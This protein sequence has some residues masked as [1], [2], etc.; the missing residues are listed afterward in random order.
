MQEKFSVTGMTCSACSAGIERTVKKLKGVQNADVS[1]MG[2][3]MSVQYDENLISSENI[4]QTVI[5]LGYGAKKYE[6]STLKTDK[7]QPNQL[8][9]RFSISLFFLIPLMYFSMGGMIGLPQP[10]I[11]IGAIVQMLL[12]VAVIIVNVKFFTSG[13]KALVKR[14]PNM[15]TLVAMGAGVSILYSFV[16]FDGIVYT[17]IIRKFHTQYLLNYNPF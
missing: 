9:K 5:E 16:F 14:V 8:K 11:L 13:A 7:P 1:L 2:E 15:D 17:K 4:I 10:N 12:T 6:E 3:C